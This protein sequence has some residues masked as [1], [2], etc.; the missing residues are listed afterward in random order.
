[1]SCLISMVV[2]SGWGLGGA[3]YPCSY[4]CS[5]VISKNSSGSYLGGGAYFIKH[6]KINSPHGRFHMSHLLSHCTIFVHKPYAHTAQN[7][8]CENIIHALYLGRDRNFKEIKEKIASLTYWTSMATGQQE[9]TWKSIQLGHK[10]WCGTERKL[11][12]TFQV[13]I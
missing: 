2:S 11:D 6:L 4:G 9:S 3:V 7:K 8:I 10:D 13:Q 1:M 12:S 5:K